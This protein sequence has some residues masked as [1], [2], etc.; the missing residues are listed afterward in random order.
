MRVGIDIRVAAPREAGQQRML[1][2]LGA[3]L[4]G[5]GHE[6]DYLS[7]RRQ[8]ADLDL[9]P[10]TTLRRLHDT[11]RRA[12]RTA[13]AELELDAF[14]INPERSRR[15]RG[16]PANVL[17]AAYGTEHYVQNLRSVRNPLERG[18]RHMARLAPWTRADLRW[19]RA[20]YEG[21]RPQPDIVCQSE[22]MKGLI[23]GSYAI[24]EEHIHIVPNAI[25]T[26]EYNPTRRLELRTEMRA[27]WGIPE[28][29]VCLL[30]LGHNFRR[31]GLWQLLETLPRVGSTRAPVHLLV[32]GSGTGDRQ[33]R[34]AAS[35]IRALGLEGRVHLL[36]PVRPAVEALAAADVL[37]FLSWHDAFGWVALEA[38][39]CGL[40]VIG[41][42]Y[43]G[44][45]ELIEQGRTG[46]IVDPGDPDDVARGVRAL[47]EP[48][49]REEM[50]AEA[51]RMAARHDEADY[52]RAV[53]EIMRIARERR[54]GPIA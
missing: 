1:W 31:K 39:G 16:V 34:K 29:A 4:G 21:T 43:A 11:P 18:V 5:E 37:A 32:A 23:L 2:R 46:L 52:F 35:L 26:A 20:F 15:Y 13:V 33:R 8:P 51:A 14:L 54:S 45:S 49:V 36:G 42:P 28:D 53:F 22:Y 47:L 3:W 7:V 24:P 41:T 9:P 6:V 17:R 40:P 50:G 27:R 30:F 44:S 12:L 10:G 48:G 25:D 38:M 19:E